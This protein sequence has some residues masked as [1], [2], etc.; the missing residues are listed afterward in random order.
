M[1]RECILAY[2]WKYFL[3]GFS[4]AFRNFSLCFTVVNSCRSCSKHH[5]FSRCKRQMKSSLTTEIMTPSLLQQ[6]P[7]M[8]WCNA[9]L[10]GGRVWRLAIRFFF[11][12]S[13]EIEKKMMAVC[14]MYSGVKRGC[15]ISLFPPPPDLVCLCFPQWMIIRSASP[16]DLWWLPVLLLGDWFSF[17]SSWCPLFSSFS[18]LFFLL[19]VFWGFYSPCWPLACIKVESFPRVLDG[20]CLIL[21]R[22]M[23][24]SF[25]VQQAVACV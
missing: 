3:S 19:S 9:F 25:Q 6:S 16:S 20:F 5:S 10:F 12:P 14:V 22:L 8:R 24:V 23:Y 15:S 17:L 4:L 11:N 18:N 21:K 7:R 1:N 13:T 2:S